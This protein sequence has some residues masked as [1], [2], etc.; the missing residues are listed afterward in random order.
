MANNSDRGKLKPV[1]A[2]KLM[3]LAVDRRASLKDRTWAKDTLFDAM[4]RM[5]PVDLAKAV[6]GLN[7]KDI[8]Q[9]STLRRLLLEISGAS[10]QSGGRK[11]PA[12]NLRPGNT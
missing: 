7:R 11:R 8:R 9:T 2:S 4:G 3:Q 12:R 5:S 10:Q 1:Q 6:K